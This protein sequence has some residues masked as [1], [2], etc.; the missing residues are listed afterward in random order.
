VV[1]VIVR[2]NDYSIHTVYSL[3]VCSFY[4]HTVENL[5]NNFT[6]TT[7]LFITRFKSKAIPHFLPPVVRTP[8]SKYGEARHSFPFP[9]VVI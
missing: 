8:L 5:F 1:V 4:I 6:D 7:R 3:V 2:S 9:F